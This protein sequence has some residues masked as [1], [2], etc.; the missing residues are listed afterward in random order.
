MNIWTYSRADAKTKAHY[1]NK[2][3]FIANKHCRPAKSTGTDRV[4]P[5]INDVRRQPEAGN[6]IDK[7]REF[8][9]DKGGGS[10][11]PNFADIAYGWSKGE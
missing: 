6:G 5:S 2:S 7:L 9:S 1:Q 11:N 4:G 3:H 10:N 8:D